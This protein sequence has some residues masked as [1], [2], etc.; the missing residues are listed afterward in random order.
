MDTDTGRDN[1]GR[2]VKGKWKGGPGGNRGTSQHYAN[3][4]HEIFNDKHFIRVATA[5]YHKAIQG[6][7]K[8]QMYWLDRQMGKI[9]E[10]VEI[11]KGESIFDKLG[12]NESK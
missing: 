8:A 3:L 1:K 9:K 12:I 6:D 10:T 2:F 11:Q 5:L 7:L 4:F